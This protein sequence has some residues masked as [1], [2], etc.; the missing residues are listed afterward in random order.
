MVGGVETMCLEVIRHFSGRA[1]NYVLVQ[2]AKQQDMRRAF[3]DLGVPITALD[4][5]P[6]NYLRTVR[7]NYRYFKSI[8]ADALICWPFGAHAFISLG[9]RLAGTSRITTHV[10]N[11]PP[12]DY[13]QAWKWRVLARLGFLSASSL[14]ACSEYVRGR[15]IYDLKLPASRIVAVNNGCDVQEFRRRAQDG[16][17]LKQ[18][19][20]FVIGMVARLNTIKDHK[21]LIQAMPPVLAK[22]TDAE[23]WLVGD[24]E[25]RESLERLTAALGLAA[26][27]KFLGTRFDVPEL[28]GQMDVFAFSTTEAE[29]FGIALIEAL[30]AGVPVVASDVGP[31]A[32]VLKQG[33][34]GRLVEPSNS[35]Q[36]AAAINEVLSGTDNTPTLSEVFEAYDTSVAARQYWNA[37]FNS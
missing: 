28:L 10:G 13:S 25:Q 7:E 6:G 18:S 1:D 23:L 2:D 21:T 32:E 5:Q 20:K 24:G 37:L 8:Q 9:A 34:W 11:A 17:K 33:K 14:V 22:Y 26:H 4:H 27:V 16:V 31:C 30:A 12:R 3:E 15:L 29:G 35:E 19:G 36:L